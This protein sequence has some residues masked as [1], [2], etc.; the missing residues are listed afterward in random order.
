MHPSDIAHLLVPSRPALV[1]DPRSGGFLL[2]ALAHPD[3]EADE[4]VSRIDRVGGDGTTSPW[5]V[6]PHDGGVVVA[7]DG[8]SVAFTRVVGGD[9]PDTHPQLVV[10]PVD[11]GEARVL[12]ALPLGVDATVAWSP[13]SSRIVATARIPEPGRYG[14]ALPDGSTLVAGAEP[15]RH[16]DRLDYRMDGVGFL[17]DR[18]RRLVVVDVAAALDGQ[19][20]TTAV[21]DGSTPVSDPVWTP[22]GQTVI[23]S[24]PRD[25]GVSETLE[26]DLY[27]VDLASGAL[28]L[29]ARS[30]GEAGSPF[31]GPD[32]TLFWAGTDREKGVV[33]VP[34]ALYAGVP[35]PDDDGVLIGR[36]LTDDRTVELEAG[37]GL[38]AARAHDVL[39]AVTTRGAVELRSVP[40]TGTAPEAPLTLD[41]LPVVLGGEVVV[42]AFSVADDLVA[43]SVAFP[44]SAGE[45]V[46][47][48][49]ASTAGAAT[50][51][52]EG[53]G[54]ESR[55][56]AGS[57]SGSGSVT[58]LT[59]GTADVRTAADVA[60]TGY[61]T[62]LREAG[63]RP[64]EELH[65]TAPDGY[66]VH[67]WLVLPE[68][69]G[70]H[71][72]LRVVH[73][74]PNAADSR[75]VFDEAQVYAAAGYAVVI[76]N[77]RGS[78]GY[79][80]DHGQA[81]VGA[82]GTLDVD[83]VL[84]LLDTAL[85]RPDLDASRVGI[86]GGSYGGFMTSWLAAKHGDRFVAAWSERAVNAWDS[87][88]GSSDIG[89]FFADAYVG[90]DPDEQRRR[91][92]LTYAG[93]V[94][95][96][97]M[98]AHSE[99]DWRCPLEQGQRQFVALKRAGVAAE[100]LLF[101]G[102]GHELSRS[103]RPSH[104]VQRFEHVLRFWGEHLPVS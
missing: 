11:G 36:A 72:V 65:G 98:V 100:F 27:R 42:R 86:M 55:P 29:H 46:L 66:P 48:E 99:Q 45:V 61:G 7:P 73:G 1:G 77:P 17:R 37:A 81:I 19:L 94:T 67:G 25:L 62:H 33:A 92:P 28:A 12:T 71:P 38:V 84:A 80:R 39:V 49:V 58:V 13:D 44:D 5:T 4:N 95:I 47:L 41:E 26:S 102:E 79:G 50:G 6:G 70:P 21:T 52:A 31:F 83:D 75:A 74:G 90:A 40:W 88:A 23:V 34:T 8:R 24:A 16:I 57:G 85:E 35:S 3:L 56:D 10:M 64:V 103:G 82:L 51:S 43:A 18:V 9:G 20:V 78:A 93:D 30:A 14:T 87:F 69:D 54:A 22:D 60:L 97:F 76:G 96:P 101:P 32:G 91:S 89:Y 15:P 68:G 63:L 59:G 53:S 2:T 104:R